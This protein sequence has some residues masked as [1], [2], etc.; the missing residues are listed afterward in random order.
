MRKIGASPLMEKQQLSHAKSSRGK[1]ITE[2]PGMVSSF[3]SLRLCVSVCLCTDNTHHSSSAYTHKYERGHEDFV[4]LR[5]RRSVCG[6]T[7]PAA[8]LR[9]TTPASGQQD[10]A[11]DARA[12]DSTHRA[13]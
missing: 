12:D 7:T 5:A 1:H 3:A 13:G 9:R 6:R 4:D 11:R 2:R 8:G 10:G